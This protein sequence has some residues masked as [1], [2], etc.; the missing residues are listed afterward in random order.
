MESRVLPV[1]QS[2]YESIHKAYKV[3]EL[4][5]LSLLDAQR[6]WIET[7]R[8]HLDVL[9]ELE[10][11]RIEIERLIGKGTSQVLSPNNNDIAKEDLS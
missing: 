7:R 4:D 6:T 11:S 3:G 8:T 5:I 10:S 1:A 9:Q 2:A